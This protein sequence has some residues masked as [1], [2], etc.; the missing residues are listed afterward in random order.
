MS[1]EIAR[2]TSPMCFAGVL[3]ALA[4]SGAIQLIPHSSDVAMFFR[5]MA[6]PAD[7]C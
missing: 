5:V 6:R 3:A 7:G 4:S 2:G 1:G